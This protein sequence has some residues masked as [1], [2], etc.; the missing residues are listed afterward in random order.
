MPTHTPYTHV[1]SQH[2]LFVFVPLV[3][4]SLL[5]KVILGDEWRSV[6]H[7]RD[8]SVDDAKQLLPGVCFPPAALSS[9][10]MST[11]D[12]TGLNHSLQLEAL[13]AE[14]DPKTCFL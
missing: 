10:G 1:Y 11:E 2:Q 9:L 13:R 7:R 14:F 3:R 6:S 4:K 12:I 5:E 8:L